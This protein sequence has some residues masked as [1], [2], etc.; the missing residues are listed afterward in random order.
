[1]CIVFVYNLKLILFY[2][3]KIKYTHVDMM[4]VLVQKCL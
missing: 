1:M 3:L 2:S 4:T